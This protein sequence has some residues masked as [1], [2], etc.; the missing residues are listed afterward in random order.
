MQ[1]PP[2]P[3]QLAS[4]ESFPTDPSGLPGAARTTVLELTDGD[5]VDLRIGAVAKKLGT[6]RCGCWATTA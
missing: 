5:V 3:D 1:Q 4:A 2:E 6:P